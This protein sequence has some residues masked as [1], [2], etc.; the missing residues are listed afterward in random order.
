MERELQIIYLLIFL[1]VGLIVFRR[2]LFG[3]YIA[4]I[5]ELWFANYFL[6]GNYYLRIRLLLLPFIFIIILIRTILNNEKLKLN[7]VARNFLIIEILMVAIVIVV[8]IIQISPMNRAIVQVARAGVPIVITLLIYFLVNSS[9]KLKTY[10]FITCGALLISCFIGI[11]QIAF[12]VP[13]YQFKH[14]LISKPELIMI[15]TYGEAS[16]LA[17]Y[18][19]PLAYQILCIL[20]IFVSLY[21]YGSLSKKRNR[22]IILSSIILSVTLLLTFCRSAIV[23]V[24]VWILGII[25]LKKKDVS[26]VLNKKK[27]ILASAVMIIVLVITTTNFAQILTVEDQSAQD[28]IPLFV[29]GVR[30]VTMYPFGIASASKY[31]EYSLEEFDSISD[32]EHADAVKYLAPHN[33][34]LNTLLYWGIAGFVLLILLFIYQFK[35]LIR[36]LRTTDNNFI[37]AVSYG[38]VGV[39]IAY[40]INSF[41]HNAGPFLGDIFYWYIIGL[42]PALVNILSREQ[43]NNGL[44]NATKS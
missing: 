41:F 23:G 44:R 43:L 2:P 6:F 39:S 14:F 36:I 12:G 16:G 5:S 22:F 24:I 17:L 4:I 11:A 38:I 20:P 27:I 26:A 31:T 32:M 30:I 29:M 34:F 3:L 35:V 40:I 8:N 15:E 10:L 18:S 42:I 19:L 7:R 28:R 25:V 21:L 37:W 1:L 9:Q 33:Q 13:F